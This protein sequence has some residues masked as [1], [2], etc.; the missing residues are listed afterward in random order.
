[1]GVDEVDKLIRHGE[2][3]L[4]GHEHREWVVNRYLRF[5]ASLAR[6]A[7]SRLVADAAEADSEAEA[8]EDTLEA[9]ARLNDQRIAAVLAALRDPSAAV[10]SVVDLGCGEGRLL[11][12]LALDPRFDRVLGVDVSTA[13]LDRAEGRLDRLHLPPQRRERISLVQGSLVYRDDRLQGFDAAA[14]VEVIEH[15]DPARLPAL[16]RAVFGDAKAGRVVVTT[17]NA[18]Y[19]ATW[20]TLPAG[21][22][23][24]RDHRF[25]WTRSEFE[26]WARRVGSEHGYRVRFQ[27]IGA[28]D[29]ALGCPTQMALFDREARP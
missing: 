9:P 2:G 4:A 5:R 26:A 27:G 29:P 20:P 23:R 21:R 17:P 13:S 24:H 10:R 3:W 7:L 8:E 1:M 12:E 18:E 11:A 28:F 14:L 22:F 16:E 15:V 19:N 25:E 6:Q